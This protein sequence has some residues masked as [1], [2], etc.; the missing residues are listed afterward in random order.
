M[1]DKNKSTI[2]VSPG[3]GFSQIYNDLNSR[4]MPTATPI[5]IIILIIVVFA[6]FFLFN[7]LGGSTIQRSENRG[8]DIIE[9]IMWGL[10]VFLVLINGVQYFFNLDIK[11]SIQSLFKPQTELDIQVNSDN[12]AKLDSIITDEYEEDP[13]PEAP[14]ETKETSGTSGTSGNLF[15]SLG[16]GEVFHIRGNKYTYNQ[17]EAL[18]RAYGA[19]L[20]DYKQVEDAYN[21]GGEWCSY[22]WSKNQHALFPTQ[23]ST[24]KKLQDM[25]GHEN[26]CGRPG[27]N[28]GYIDN[29]NVKYGVN[30]FG[31]KRKITP[32]EEELMKSTKPYP[33][34]QKEKNINNLVDKYKHN[35]DNILLAPF[36]NKKW[37]A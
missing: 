34:T 5:I 37:K 18:C 35:L 16:G 2:E 11:T 8:L 28:G 9:I 24:W 23:I 7:S 22:G 33:I 3:H 1:S 36:N 32:L 26:D 10:F 30:C 14:K 12:L 21:A 17:A 31:K 15:S 29:P 4:T 25:R 20:A 19:E 13:Q 6:Y 27:V